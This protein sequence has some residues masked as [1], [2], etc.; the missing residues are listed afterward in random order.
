MNVD[1]KDLLAAL[2]EDIAPKGLPLGLPGEE[3]RRILTDL[4]MKP[5]PVGS[6]HRLWTIGELSAH[7]ALAYLA[8]WIR[9]WFAGAEAREQRLMEAN[10]RLALKTFQRL[11]YLRGAMAKVGQALGAFPDIL[12]DEIVATLDRLHFEAPPMH[13]SLIREVVSDELGAGPEDLFGSFDRDAFAAASLG[14]VHRATLKSGERVAVKIQ[15]PGIARAIDADF[16]NL[17]ALMLPLRLG[18]TWESMKGYLGEIRRMLAFEI[19][20]EHEAAN[21]LEA[22]G[23]FRPDDGIVVPALYPEYSTKRVLTTEYLTGLHLADFLRT[24]PSQ[25]ARDEFGTRIYR[26]HLRMFCRDMGYADPHSGNYLFMNDG[27]LGLL[28]FGCIQ[29]FGPE[30]RELMRIAENYIQNPEAFPEFLR[31][32][33]GLDDDE[34]ADEDYVQAM[35]R[36]ISWFNEPIWGEQPFD[37]GDPEHLRRGV[38]GLATLVRKRY[39]RSHPMVLYITRSGYALA[40]LLLGLRAR[41][42]MHTLAARE[43]ELRDRPR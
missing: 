31:H 5:V 29:R 9:G 4:S 3:L 40:A 37:F 15:Y 22:R 34:L 6:L 10:L 13:F 19:D 35:E 7:I 20:Y 42:D 1:L 18:K 16:R 12:P 17:N 43:L 41:I 24:N 38:D 21:L 36:S 39:T 28:D 33:C 8:L 25:G 23:L 14:Q 27:R 30:E 26:A 2:P 11:G 32:A